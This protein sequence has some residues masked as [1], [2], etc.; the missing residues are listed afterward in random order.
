MHVYVCTCLCMSYLK[1]TLWS[2][3]AFI[4]FSNTFIVLCSYICIRKHTHTD[5]QTDRQR[6][7]IAA[8]E[9]W[10]W[11][12]VCSCGNRG[13]RRQMGLYMFARTPRLHIRKGYICS[14]FIHIYIYIVQNVR[15][16]MAYMSEHTCIRKQRH[17]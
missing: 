1:A 2:Q 11:S 9:A 5:R 10:W 12:N 17:R 6:I 13:A 8:C 4:L 3:F 15:K 7:H 16:C 14:L